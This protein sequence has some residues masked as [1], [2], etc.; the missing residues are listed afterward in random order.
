VTALAH[1]I[2]FF[3]FYIFPLHPL[4]LLNLVIFISVILWGYSN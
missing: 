3:F 2:F 4:D 1:R